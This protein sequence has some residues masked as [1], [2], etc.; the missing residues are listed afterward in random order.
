MSRN[1]IALCCVAAG[2]VLMAACNSIPTDPL[3]PI[4]GEDPGKIGAATV[5]TGDNGCT[6]GYW[7][8][9]LESWPITSLSPDQPVDTVFG[10]LWLYPEVGSATLLEALSFS[11]GSD[12]LGA[13][14]LLVRAGVAAVL[15]ALH[16]DVPHMLP[17][18]VLNIVNTALD[19]QDRDTIL[20]A[21]ALLGDRN[22]S[23][24]PL[25]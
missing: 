11:G 22:D 7:K 5:V 3:A 2:A 15:N 21:A 20:A 17:S 25:D 9:H 23:V 19:S 8:N 14:R 13:V 1:A 12:L 6:P 10:E 4:G 18:E 24:C 16:P